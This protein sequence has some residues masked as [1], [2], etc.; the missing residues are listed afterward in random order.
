MS[1][2]ILKTENLVKTYYLQ[3]E[4]IEVLRG[5]ELEVKKGSF[6]VIFGP[7]GSGKSTLLNILGSLDRPSEGKVYFDSI[8]LFSYDDNGLSEIRNKKIGFVFQ[9][10]HLL[11]EFSCLENIAMP[12]LINGTSPKK[13][14]KQAS[15]LLEKFGMADKVN[16]L[17]DELSGGEKQRVA[18]ARALINDPLLLLAD[19]PSGNLDEE[20]TNK[21]LE[22]FINLKNEGRTIVLV[23]H[24]L[25]IA[26][27]ASQAFKLKEGR[28]YAL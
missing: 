5:I 10:H 9:F 18:I 22:V 26:R 17:P 7:S 6:V 23:T 3:Q 4:T 11:G 2:V 12:A 21:L 1:E 19:E 28:L 15:I 25:D 13:A 27:V 24:A 16:R 8:D 14:F 20:N